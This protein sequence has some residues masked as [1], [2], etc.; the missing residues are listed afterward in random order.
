MKNL[1]FFKIFGLTLV[2]VAIVFR[3]IIGNSIDKMLSDL[4][5]YGLAFIGIGM[6]LYYVKKKKEKKE[7]LSSK[8]E[9]L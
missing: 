4:I 8:E 9:S 3:N 5:Y 1:L 7:S 6:E 2:G